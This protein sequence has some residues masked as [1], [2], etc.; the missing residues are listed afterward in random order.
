MNIILF[1]HQNSSKKGAIFK[2]VIDHNFNQ[3]EIQIFQ[4]VKAF[5]TRLK[6]AL[7]F[8]K[9]IYIIFIDSENRL[10]ELTLLIDLLENKR[11][12]LILPT[13][14]S[15]ILSVAHQFFPRVFT[16]INDT[17]D[18]LCAVL[19]KMIN[20]ETKNIMSYGKGGN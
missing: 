7:I 3:I 2:H 18:D 14:L 12:L 20:Q 16:F 10:K 11:I 8:E 6:Q 5:K 4:T 9:E 19:T 1:I 15:A 13:D 17:Y